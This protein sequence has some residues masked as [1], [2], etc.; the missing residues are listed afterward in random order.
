MPDN[1]FSPS[2]NQKKNKFTCI[3]NKIIRN[4]LISNSGFRLLSYL[5]SNSDSWIVYNEVVKRELD[6]GRD[7][8]D[9]AIKNL[10]FLGYLKKTQARTDKGTFSH[11]QYEWD[12]EPIFL[13]ENHEILKKEEEK[14]NSNNST[15]GAKPVDGSIDVGKPATTNTNNKNTNNNEDCLFT[16]PVGNGVSNKFSKIHSEGH[17][18]KCSL[19][20]VFQYAISEQKNWK[21]EDII[22]AWKILEEFKSPIRCY[23][24][25]I[26]G[27]IVNMKRKEKS[28][29]AIKN[30][31]KK[32]MTPEEMKMNKIDKTI[33]PPTMQEGLPS[34]IPSKTERLTK[35]NMTFWEKTLQELA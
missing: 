30:K 18:V 7:L 24:H 29:L 6:W 9:G 35:G 32:W 25:F 23:L 17:E 12:F 19:Q 13:K 33:S 1:T 22:S 28:E 14:S 10:F 26:D 5:A 34:H 3:P 15:E 4:N 21:T 27:T 11:N 8:L 2:E 31:G 16:L 20:E